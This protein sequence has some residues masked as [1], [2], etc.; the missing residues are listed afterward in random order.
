MQLWIHRFQ[1]RQLDGFAQQLFVERDGETPVDVMPVEHRQP[2]DPTDK[3]EI[4]EMILKETPTVK[5]VIRRE[6]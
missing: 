6:R 1:V 4:R 5:E 2:H 3:V